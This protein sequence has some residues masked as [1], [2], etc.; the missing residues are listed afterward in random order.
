MKPI[1]NLTQHLATDEQKKAGVIDLTGE[2]R[3][4]L[5]PL[6][7]FSEI[8]TVQELAERASDI[9]DVVLDFI[10]Y[11]LKLEEY[12][13][14]VKEKPYFDEY[15]LLAD[16]KF[17]IGGAPYFMPVLHNMLLDFTTVVYAFSKRVSE[18]VQNP[19]GTVSKKTIFKHAGFVEFSKEG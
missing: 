2:Y 5:I 17:M 15:D 19:D 11:D 6:L 14:I 3:E 8:P 4:D 9:I 12:R 10:C 7:T 16:F 1:I 18:E 13:E